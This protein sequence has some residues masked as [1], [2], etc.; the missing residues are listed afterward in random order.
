[1]RDKLEQFINENREAFDVFEPNPDLWKGIIKEDQATL[2]VVKSKKAIYYFY[3]IAAV[4]L[5]AVL[6]VLAYEKFIKNTKEEI[7]AQN[8]QIKVDPEIVELLEAE[9][10]YKNEVGTKINELNHFSAQFPKV[11][12]DVMNDLAELDSAYTQLK[13]ELGKNIYKKEVIESM[14]ENYRL[15]LSILEDVLTQLEKIDEKE[16]SK[17][18]KK[19]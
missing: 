3:R 10:Y 6:S 18:T 8:E 12:T 14:M 2:P 9:A 19:I 13:V 4:L 15:K 5:I 17:E 11:K 1:M 7:I 16:V